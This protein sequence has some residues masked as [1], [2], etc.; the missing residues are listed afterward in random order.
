MNRIECA[1]HL[2]MTQNPY[3]AAEHG[4][5][6]EPNQHN[7]SEY[8]ADFGRPSGLNHEEYDQDQNSYRHCARLESAGRGIE[9]F[10][11]AQYRDR[12]RDDAMRINEGRTKHPKITSQRSRPDQSAPIAISASIPP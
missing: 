10:H 4:H 1:K 12:G 11:G 6:R 3:D 2:R 5:R 7:W 8:F 9:A